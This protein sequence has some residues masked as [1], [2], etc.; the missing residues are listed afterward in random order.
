LG[1]FLCCGG[2]NGL[3]LVVLAVLGGLCSMALMG[4]IW[5]V[6]LFCGGLILHG[7]NWLLIFNC[8]MIKAN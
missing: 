6:W 3:N 7:L 2:F 4:A 1:L 8:A 5:A